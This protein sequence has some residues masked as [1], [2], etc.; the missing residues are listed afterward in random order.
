LQCTD[1]WWHDDVNE[2]R[3]LFTLYTQHVRY[4]SPPCSV[5]HCSLLTLEACS[6]R[7][8]NLTRSNEVSRRHESQ[9]SFSF[10]LYV[11][12]V[13]SYR[14]A[15]L[16]SATNRRKNRFIIKHQK[17]VG[18]RLNFLLLIGLC[19]NGGH[20]HTSIYMRK[21]NTITM[22]EIWGRSGVCYLL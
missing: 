7:T 1:R 2:L 5:S 20:F 16:W 17:E 8:C 13:S 19:I 10:Q 14:I 12:F 18:S 9:N 15:L 6:T 22:S 21:V 11:R 3:Q 4:S